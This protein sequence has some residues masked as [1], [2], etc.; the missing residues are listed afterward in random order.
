MKPNDIDF[1]REHYQIINKAREQYLRTCISKLPFRDELSTALDLG[2][3]AGYFSGILHDLG[4]S[5]TGLDLRTENIEVCRERY[6]D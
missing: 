2:C 4:F 6:P 3:G 5:V 1:D